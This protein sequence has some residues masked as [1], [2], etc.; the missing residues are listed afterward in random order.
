MYSKLIQSSFLLGILLKCNDQ[1][2]SLFSTKRSSPNA[3]Y[4][5]VVAK[6]VISKDSII[7]CTTGTV[8]S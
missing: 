6:I 4:Q 7:F 3:T 2:V 8:I 1:G 5:C